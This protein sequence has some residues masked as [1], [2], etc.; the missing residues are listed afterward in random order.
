M[1]I[2]VVGNATQLWDQMPSPPKASPPYMTWALVNLRGIY[3]MTQNRTKDIENEH[4]ISTL[5]I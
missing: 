2:V 5:S 4:G 1:P 3:K